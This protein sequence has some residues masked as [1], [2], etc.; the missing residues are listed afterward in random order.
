MLV[1]KQNIQ[2]VFIALLAT[3]NNAFKGATSTWQ[4]VA[5][6]VPSTT[7]QNDYSWLS[8]FPKMREWIGEKVVKSLEA[9]NY[10]IKNKDWETT[11]RVK[12]NDIEDDQLGQYAIHTQM[13]G[14]S[15]AQ[16]PD[17]IVYA[18]LAGGFTNKCY[19]G[20]YF[21]DVDH[22]VRQP[23]GT[24]ASVS[25][26]GT[27]RLSV[28]SLA[29]AQASLGAAD[30]ALIEMKDD[31]GRTLS[32]LPN[33]LVVGTGQKSVANALMTTD[34]LED[35]KPNPFK[36]AYE[37]LVEPRLARNSWFLMDTKK[38]VKP[39]I[40]QTRKKPEFVQQ[41]SMDS[42]NVYLR[43]EFLFGAEARANGGYGFWQQAYGSNGT[44]DPA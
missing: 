30:L 40:L 10:T 44:T 32:V 43:G 29:A 36:G 23:D 17:D 5:M 26:K 9:F 33:L 15:A 28:A 34:R 31:E 27:M 24:T 18:L 1:N 21:F 2:N 19:D 22:P 20:Q 14:D 11:I 41:T 3:F 25:N 37:M 13:A 38:P 8:N 12:R 16:L 6:E 42:D 7:G 35:G 39:I 4:K